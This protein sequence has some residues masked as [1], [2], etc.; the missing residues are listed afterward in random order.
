MNKIY[1]VAVL[2]LAGAA[3]AAVA[4]AA[5]P[6]LTI[7]DLAA[8]FAAPAD[9]EGQ[10]GLEGKVAEV[11]A[12]ERSFVMV[13]SETEGGCT[14]ECC[15]P[16][17]LTIEVPTADWK[18]KLPKVGDSLVAVGELTPLTVGFDLAVKEVRSGDKVLL[19]RK[20]E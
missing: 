20:T 4:I 10:V 18:G 6:K 17:R 12:K 2:A 15:A 14:E 8:A 19:S 11:Q 1:L 3:L 9:F 16:D 5:E 7:V 13:S